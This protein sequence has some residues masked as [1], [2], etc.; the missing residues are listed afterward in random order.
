MVVTGTIVALAGAFD[1]IAVRQSL[2]LGIGL[3]V[4]G[5]ALIVRGILRARVAEREQ[6][7]SWPKEPPRR[8]DTLASCA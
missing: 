1:L 5:I 2:V 7:R 3:R 6:F 4:V 8:P